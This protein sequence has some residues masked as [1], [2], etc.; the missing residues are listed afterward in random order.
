M[1]L[2]NRHRVYPN[3]SNSICFAPMRV[4]HSI[5]LGGERNNIAPL[6]NGNN[7]YQLGIFLQKK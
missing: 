2:G 5:V 3:G 7:H 1:G 4:I 6:L